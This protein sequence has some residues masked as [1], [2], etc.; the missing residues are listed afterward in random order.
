MPARIR[1]GRLAVIVGVWALAVFAAPQEWKFV[2]AFAG[3]PWVNGHDGGGGEDV[4][5]GQSARRSVRQVQ[6]VAHRAPD[7]D[8]ADRARRVRGHDRGAAFLAGPDAESG[9]QCSFQRAWHGP[10]PH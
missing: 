5:P 6:S 2:V 9:L 10:A 1:L 3:Y 8:G 4:Q 7:H